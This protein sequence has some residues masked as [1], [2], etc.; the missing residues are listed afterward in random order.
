MSM[1]PLSAFQRMDVRPLI[2]AGEEPFPK[3][4][5]RAD[6]LQRGEGLVVI[7]PFLP[8]PLVENLR[9]DGFASRIERGQDGHWMVYF[10]RDAD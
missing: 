6:A 7:A 10:W 3:I 8:S 4:R 5:R 9:G 2:A 1:P